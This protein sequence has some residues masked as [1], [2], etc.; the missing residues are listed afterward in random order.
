MVELKNIVS[1][2]K[3]AAKELIGQLESIDAKIVELSEQR[4]AITSGLVSKE[5]FLQ[6]MRAHFQ[7]KGESF[8][9]GIIKTIGN[10]PR[11]YASLERA[12]S[13]G[14][15]FVGINFLTEGNVPVDITD[16]AIYYYFGDLLVDRLGKSLAGLQWPE[17][18]IPAAL[19]HEM[20]LD[21]KQDIAMLEKQRG[22][23]VETL[24]EAGI[25]SI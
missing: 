10:R 8:E 14:N 6:Y 9:R 7:R 25:T 23:L 2:L 11:D 17:D 12:N 13:Q 1:Q 19:R 3:S 4:D 21:I 15:S 24:K 16:G 18:A 22:G 20:L 5:D